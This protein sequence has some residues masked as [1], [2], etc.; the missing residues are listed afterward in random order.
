VKALAPSRKVGRLFEL[1]GNKEIGKRGEE[2]NLQGM[3]RTEA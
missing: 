1:V 3:G 2:M